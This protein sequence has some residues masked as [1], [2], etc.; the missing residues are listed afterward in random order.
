MKRY[1][2]YEDGYW[3]NNDEF[4]Y[5]SKFRDRGAIKHRVKY[6]KLFGFLMILI[7]KIA[8]HDLKPILID[9]KEVVNE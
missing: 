5:W 8:N 2:I 6:F 1:Y 4:G 3:S 7:M 9:V